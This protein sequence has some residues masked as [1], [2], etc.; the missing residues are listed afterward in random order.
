MRSHCRLNH[1]AAHTTM[2]TVPTEQLHDNPQFITQ[3]ILTFLNV[4]DPK[5]FQDFYFTERS[6]TNK[7]ANYPSLERDLPK[8]LIRIA[9]VVVQEEMQ[10]SRNMT[11]WPCLPFK[12]L[13]PHLLTPQKHRFF[14]PNC[15]EDGGY[16][17]CS[18]NFDFAEQQEA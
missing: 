7:M 3:S 17:K 12:E 18:V 5:L 1:V 4:K 6:G 11:K 16:P 8:Y 14:A 13:A 15:S 9:S 2:L 10:R